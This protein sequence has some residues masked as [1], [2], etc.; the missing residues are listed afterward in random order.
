[1]L[2]NHNIVINSLKGQQTTHQQL[3]NK[4][5]SQPSIFSRRQR[6]TL[7]DA[8]PEQQDDYLHHQ[9]YGQHALP[10]VGLH[11]HPGLLPLHVQG[12]GGWMRWEMH[13]LP[14]DGD[15]PSSYL[16]L[17]E[18]IRKESQDRDGVGQVKEENY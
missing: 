12:D 14:N 18:V 3:K 13:R 11:H 8:R 1:M 2:I 17:Q 9:Q 10:A 16:P 4:K 15:I 7:P 5:L 6:P